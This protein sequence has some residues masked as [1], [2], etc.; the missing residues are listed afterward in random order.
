MLRGMQS[1][2]RSTDSKE[3]VF[4]SPGGPSDRALAR[5]KLPDQPVEDPVL[6]LLRR[7]VSPSPVLAPVVPDEV[8]RGPPDVSLPVPGVVVVDVAVDP[9]TA[10]VLLAPSI[11]PVVV[12]T[13]GDAPVDTESEGSSPKDV[14]AGVHGGSE[15]ASTATEVVVALPRSAS[16]NVR[17]RPARVIARSCHR[18]PEG[19]ATSGN[20]QKELNS[21]A[22]PGPNSTQSRSLQHPIG[23]PV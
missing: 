7:P 19:Q 15:V 18:R 9:K 5:V 22:P 14:L 17:Q 1:P 11:V 21:Q 4:R 12:S 10:V 3:T 8:P 13:E 20:E 6:L 23:D 2:E 16:S